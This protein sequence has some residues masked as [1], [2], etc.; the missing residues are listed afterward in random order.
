MIEKAG[1]RKKLIPPPVTKTSSFRRSIYDRYL[2][3]LFIRTRRT[4]P[5]YII[6]DIDPS[7]DP[8]HGQQVLSFFHGYYDST[9]ISRSSSSTVTAVFRWRRGCGRVRWRPVVER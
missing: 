1:G 9:S 7:D 4:P 2:P 8:T 3:E 5:A 6:F